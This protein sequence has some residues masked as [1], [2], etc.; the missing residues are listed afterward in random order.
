MSEKQTTLEQ[1]VSAVATVQA[2]ANKLT[3]DEVAEAVKGSPLP[4]LARLHV[5]Y[6]ENIDALGDAKTTLQKAF[7]W[8]RISH[9]PERMEA[10]ELESM[11][12]E[13]VGRMYLTTQFMASIKA[14]C[15]EGAYQYLTDHGH[16]DIIQSTVNASSL[17]ALAKQ[18]I[19]DNDPLPKDLFNTNYNSAAVIAKK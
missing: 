13:G 11:T 5:G 3:V 8:L 15:K 1:L 17:K 16:G 7:D 18:K 4:A 10:E 6:R 14:D 12:I 2:L 19:K 9:I